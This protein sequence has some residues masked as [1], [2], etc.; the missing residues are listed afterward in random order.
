M[1]YEYY[2]HKEYIRQRDTALHV[3]S[4]TPTDTEHITAL[5]K[6]RPTVSLD[7]PVIP[8]IFHHLPPAF[9]KSQLVHRERY[10]ELTNTQGTL[11]RVNWYTGNATKS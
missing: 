8:V 10:K 6:S 9:D 3:T 7:Q 1:Q 4:K 2:T 5:L 11:Q